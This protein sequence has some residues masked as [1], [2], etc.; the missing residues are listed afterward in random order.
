MITSED[1]LLSS[2]Y[3]KS[4][5]S[6]IKAS[7]PAYCGLLCSSTARSD[8]CLLC[9]ALAKHSLKSTV[10]LASA[11]FHAPAFSF[12]FYFPPW[13][14]VLPQKAWH[15]F[16]LFIYSVAWKGR[17]ESGRNWSCVN[18]LTIKVLGKVAIMHIKNSRYPHKGESWLWALDD[19]HWTPLA[20]VCPVE[21]SCKSWIC[22]T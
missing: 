13:H 10:C 4:Q 9:C 11:T 1:V 19:A 12:S 6:S 8:C 18:P 7:L 5:H 22:V 17:G 16:A 20:T 15:S 14:P 21:G 3:H 2:V